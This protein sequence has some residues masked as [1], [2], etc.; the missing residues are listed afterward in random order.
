MA[1][2]RYFDEE[3]LQAE[4]VRLSEEVEDFGF[5]DRGARPSSMS[6][7]G[8]RVSALALE[9]VHRGEQLGHEEFDRALGVPG[10]WYRYRQL[11]R[12]YDPRAPEAFSPSRLWHD[13]QII[14]REEPDW[15]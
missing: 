6:P 5:P 2:T 11:I 3:E 14:R 8:R 4:V 15:D 10:W 12:Q 9:A 7:T 1:K 13:L